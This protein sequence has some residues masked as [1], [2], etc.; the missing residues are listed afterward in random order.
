VAGNK[1]GYVY[2][3]SNASMPGLVKIGKSRRGGRH[4]AKEIYQTGVPTPF[5]MEFELYTNDCDVL[6]RYAHERL[7][8]DRVSESR[9]FFKVDVSKAIAAVTGAHLEEYDYSV[10]WGQL[11][12]I[13]YTLGMMH[14]KSGI[15]K[16]ACPAPLHMYLL[17]EHI[18][19][20]AM[21]EANN[22]YIEACKKRKERLA[23]GAK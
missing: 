12:E 15:G 11:G 7:D 8:R 23:V 14:L 1:D 21:L 10:I 4:R 13:E 22:K 20:E 2:I 16:T 5:T 6:E 9:E 18:S 3:L 19:K 17:L